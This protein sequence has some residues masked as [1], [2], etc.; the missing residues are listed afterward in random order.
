[1]SI[2]KWGASSIL[3]T[4]SR[5]A[6]LTALLMVAVGC[7]ARENMQEHSGHGSSN[8]DSRVS[9]S[10]DGLTISN[11]M[12]SESPLAGGNGAVYLTIG[13]ESAEQLVSVE[14]S[15]AAMA[16]LH[17]SLD[18]NGVMRMEPR[19]DGFEIPAGG[20]VELTQGGKHVML[21]NLADA[22]APGDEIDLTLNFRD[23]EPVTLTVPVMALGEMEHN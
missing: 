20:Q 15:A 23:H 22:L 5:L 18:D 8:D 1:M 17:E 11:V 12:A 2:F 7:G 16:E 9:V 19:P 21:M 6:L 4:L 13:S 14:S 10:V 3:K